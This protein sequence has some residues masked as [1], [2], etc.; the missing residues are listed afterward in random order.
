MV[1]IITHSSFPT[2]IKL[3]P[4]NQYNIGRRQSTDPNE[5]TFLLNHPSISGTHIRIIIKDY[6][7]N[8]KLHPIRIT[9]VSKFGTICRETNVKLD[10]SVHT[11]F[12]N[13][14]FSL[15]LGNCPEALVFQY[16]S[17][18]FFCSG[19]QPPKKV[20]EM[21]DKIGRKVE[22]IEQSTHFVCKE[23]RENE[24]TIYALIHNKKMIHFKWFQQL[25]IDEGKYPVEDE[26]RPPISKESKRMF[27]EQNV[28]FTSMIRT[29][30]FAGDYFYTTN[31]NVKKY[32]KLCGGSVNIQEYFGMNEN[33]KKLRK[34]QSRK[35]A[36]DYIHQCC[37]NSQRNYSQ[38]NSQNSQIQMSLNNQQIQMKMEEESNKFK[39]LND[40][41][42]CTL[43]S[44]DDGSGNVKSFNEEYYVITIQDL[45]R[46]ILYQNKQYLY[47]N[48]NVK[49]EVEEMEEEL[50]N[51]NQNNK[52]I[53]NS[54]NNKTSQ[55]NLL[56][57]RYVSMQR[58]I[59]DVDTN[60]TISI[61]IPNDL[62]EVHKIKTED[63]SYSH[64]QKQIDS[65]ESMSEI[66]KGIPNNVKNS[67]DL[68]E[69]QDKKQ[70]ES[71]PRKISLYDEVMK[72]GK[73]KTIELI[74][75]VS[76]MSR[77][78]RTLTELESQN[79]DE[80]LEESN[81]NEINK[82]K[83]MEE[84]DEY[85]Q[86]RK[87]MRR[88]KRGFDITQQMNSIEID[89]SNKQNTQQSMNQSTNN[90][91]SSNTSIDQNTFNNYGGIDESS[92]ME[93][94]PTQPINIQCKKFKKQTIGHLLDYFNDFE[95]VTMSSYIK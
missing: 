91:F 32:I 60:E 68:K 26:F 1:W 46:A 94:M 52:S 14:H 95:I 39:M 25:K 17:Y 5:I 24:P 29:K 11:T 93:T 16:E 85:Q 35:D 73:K 62:S 12:S 64:I 30:M 80:L 53:N 7:L 83:Q 42:K 56:T 65:S 9:D 33:E 69:F 79:I 34:K 47:G 19:I 45:F 63:E 86:P 90:L 23:I 82:N 57:Q 50:I 74:E 31:E 41:D 51:E 48:R 43:F 88:A 10:K 92:M 28:D 75:S 8:S 70:Q 49:E 27:D 20:I 78:K 15:L 89:E 2:P 21:M 66:R 40:N 55:R 13:Y 58:E 22:T 37:V 71:K 18:E 3:L 4:G 36:L 6:D 54:M 67:K 44:I 87:V 59:H 72:A 76:E 81:D 61:D 84:E 38:Y 77:K